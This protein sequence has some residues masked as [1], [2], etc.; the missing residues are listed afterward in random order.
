MTCPLCHEATS[1][2]EINTTDGQV[3]DIDECLNCGGHFLP[4]V[5]AN[6]ISLNTAKNVDSVVPK[7]NSVPLASPTCPHCHQNM[8]SI[9]DDSVPQTVTVFSC[10]NNH[11]E[12]YP[13]D[14]LLLF[15][16]AQDA[17]INFH[18]LWGIPL[19]SAFAVMI[20]VLVIFSAITV[21]P[22]LLNQMKLNQENR[23]KAGEILTQPLITP[24][25]ANQVLISF[26]TQNS[27]K[28]SLT[29]TEGLNKTLDVSLEP[30]TNHLLSVDGLSPQTTYKYI[31]NIDDNG[32][33]VSTT[34]Y[35]FSTP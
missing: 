22:N 24:I 12:F 15:K 29:F 27:V 3:T 1:A 33:K 14:Q 20:P 30:N 10:P 7:A 32:R 17:K 9:K 2:I 16:R 19:K 34:E 6:F 23:V 35:I 13:K 21:V 25:S 18:K 4:P 26:S 28:T 31:I 5:L 11:G 8:S